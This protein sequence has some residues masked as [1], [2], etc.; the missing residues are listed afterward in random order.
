LNI[1]VAAVH[2]SPTPQCPPFAITEQLVH[3]VAPVIA[4][5][6]AE[7]AIMVIVVDAESVLAHERT[8]DDCAAIL[9]AGEV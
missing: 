3:A 4:E 7:R 6:F 1:G 8:V 5:L 2:A 9:I